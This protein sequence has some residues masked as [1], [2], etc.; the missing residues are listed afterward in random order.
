M[1]AASRTRFLNFRDRAAEAIWF[2][3]RLDGR[4]L[5]VTGLRGQGMALGLLPG[6]VSYRVLHH[7]TIPLL[8]VH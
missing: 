6:S 2:V 7:A 1:I 8:I 3:A 5:I 4:D